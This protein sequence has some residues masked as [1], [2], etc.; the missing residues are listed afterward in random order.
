MD[1]VWTH[2]IWTVEMLDLL[3]I[4][5]VSSAETRIVTIFEEFLL[6]CPYSKETNAPKY[7]NLKV[8]HWQKEHRVNRR[9]RL[10]EAI[11]VCRSGEGCELL[12]P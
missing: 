3:S 12:G 1:G 2:K 8:L 4:V 10:W 5:T 7:D 11:V 9:N 6:D